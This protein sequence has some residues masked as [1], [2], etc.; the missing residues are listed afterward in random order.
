VD[1]HGVQRVDRPTRNVLVMSDASGDR[2]FVGFGGPNESFADTAI[3]AASL[4]EDVL[5]S[6]SAL[7]TGSLGLAF[8]DTAAAMQ[9]A[10]EVAK[11]GAC[12]A[13]APRAQRAALGACRAAPL[14]AARARCSST[15]TGGPCSGRAWRRRARSSRPTSRAPTS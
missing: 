9:R 13:R 12:E 11:R 6:A 1:V 2:E 5:S 8:P 3:D 7:V 14:S 4:P 10:L 15:S